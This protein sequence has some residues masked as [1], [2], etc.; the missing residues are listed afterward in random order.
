MTVMY[1]FTPS[2]TLLSF[3]NNVELFVLS[4]N[5]LVFLDKIN[6][7]VSRAYKFR[8]DKQYNNNTLIEPT[9]ARPSR[10]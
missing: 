1:I 6:T 8:P 3:S 5:L 10:N 9:H 4:L 7:T 2:S